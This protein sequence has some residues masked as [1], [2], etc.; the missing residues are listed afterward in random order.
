MKPM[1]DLNDFARLCHEASER[2]GWTN[3]NRTDSQTIN[4]MVSENSEAVEDFRNKRGVNE[5]YYEAKD[6]ETGQKFI[7]ELKE[8]EQWPESDRKKAEPKP[9]G[10][11]IELADTVIRIG[12]QCGTHGMNLNVAFA[13]ANAEDVRVRE[14]V[15]DALADAT[16]YISSAWRHSPRFLA[17]RTF[18]D[19]E[20]EKRQFCLQLAKGLLSIVYFCSRAGIDLWD[21]VEKKMA[22]NETREMLHGGK[23]I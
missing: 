15:N 4:L 21:A 1:P 3:L 16:M 20:K 7:T 14:D 18:A 11:P 13:L 12:Q 6:P 5:I 9:C 19:P 10:I 8:I 22:F 17:P 23:R 2:K